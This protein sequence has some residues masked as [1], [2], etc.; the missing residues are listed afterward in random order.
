MALLGDLV[1]NLG[2]NSK[3]FSGGLTRASSKLKTFGSG[4][5]RGVGQ[6]AKFGAAATAA[7]VALGAVFVRSSLESIDSIAKLSDRLGIATEDITA[8]QHAGQ[9]MGVSATDVN[10]GLEQL[11]K[12]LGEVATLGKSEAKPALDALGL[13]ADQ[14]ANMPLAD[15]LGLVSDRMNGLATQ[16]DKAAVANALFGRAGLKM[17]NFLSLGSA[18][19]KDARA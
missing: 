13:T 4:V 19:L 2:L 7:G 5:A 1:V 11:T 3:K 6:M 12:R 14:L 8:F 9:L 15:A 18:G 16:S 17:L 10:K